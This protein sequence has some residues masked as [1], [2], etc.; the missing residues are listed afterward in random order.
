MLQITPWERRV[1]ELIAEG[2]TANDIGACFG[3]PIF[4]AGR[5]MTALFARMGVET[6]AEAV[7]GALRRGLVSDDAPLAMISTTRRARLQLP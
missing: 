2:K 7:A 1:L 5:R 3:L 4:E 6:R